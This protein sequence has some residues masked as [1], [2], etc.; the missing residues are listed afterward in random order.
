[1]PVPVTMPQLSEAMT[2]GTV[3]RWLKAPGE[4]VTADE[5]LLEILSDKV[6]AELPAPASGVL[7]QV[8][9]EEGAAVPVGATLAVIV[10]EGEAA[11]T[12]TTAA[13]E[14]A[15]PT[16]FAP[17][18]GSVP[19]AASAATAAPS[20]PEEPAPA[21][22]TAVP[23]VAASPGTAAPG[24]TAP[25]ADGAAPG[26]RLYS[27]RVQQLAAEHGLNEAELQAIEGSGLGGRLT[28][29]DVLAYLARR[30]APA[31]APPEVAGMAALAP[32]AVTVAPT[33]P[34][35]PAPPV[36]PLAAR[37]TTDTGATAGQDSLLP[38]T[39]M[40]RAIAAQMT[41][42]VVT[43]VHAWL[44]V[45][46]DMS[47]VAAA[48]D[49]R[50]AAFEATEGF[51]LTYLPFF[52]AAVSGALRA[53][54]VLNAV[55]ED[56]QLVE[57]RELNLGVA[58]AV[59]GGLTVPVIA[60]ADGLNLVGLARAIRERAERARANRLTAAD[61]DGGTFT[62]NNTG[63]VGSILSQPIINVP[64]VAIVTMEAIVRRPVVTAADAIAIRP[65]MNACL[66]YDARAVSGPAAAAFLGEVKRR[67][68]NWRD[69]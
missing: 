42:S 35:A 46:I 45:E 50:R 7:Q 13:G 6:T 56:E 53:H 68:E 40:R 31:P 9:V 29:D 10:A 67:L 33:A 22:A 59:D 12:E 51:S 47:A 24:A 62:V 5:P 17:S 37:A 2:E 64:Q 54:P 23:A 11:P 66:S 26:R 4:R 25:G 16:P 15:A 55:W 48:R 20:A 65:L 61:L 32:A 28:S 44:S 36:P 57:R 8:T 27:P 19:Q 52:A 38:L 3:G 63:A 34:T 1:M 39:P 14:T 60:G 18:P 69:E 21:A 43:A 30:P 58:I 41:R 49:R